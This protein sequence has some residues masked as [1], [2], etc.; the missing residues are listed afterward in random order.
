M[1]EVII[2]STININDYKIEFVLPKE[3]ENS[4]AV[5][6]HLKLWAKLVKE[7]E[8]QKLKE[9]RIKKLIEINAKIK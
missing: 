9:T 7:Q 2:G 4:I 5:S 6:E 1:K 8:L 3:L